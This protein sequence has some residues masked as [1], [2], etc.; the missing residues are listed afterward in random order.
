V[1]TELG[2][3][4]LLGLLLRDHLLGTKT[5]LSALALGNTATSTREDDIEVH[6][7]NTDGRIV[8]KTKIDVLLD[9]ET[10]VTLRGEASIRELELL[11]GKTLLENLLGLITLDGDEG[12]DLLITTNGEGTDGKA[13]GREDGLLVG[14]LL[15]HLCGTGQT[16]A[17]L[18]DT[19][20][21]HQF[22][23]AD[24]AHGVNL[25]L[26]FSALFVSIND[27]I[28]SCV[29]GEYACVQIKSIANWMNSDQKQMKSIFVDSIIVYL[30]E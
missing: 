7:I 24:V 17:R 18:T 12:G 11:D 30:I 20:V 25:L 1:T 10:E 14:Q 29:G 21:H 6:T 27:W 3:E 4:P 13:S 9:T 23:N 19:A 8:L 5:A 28:A 15:K 16:I 22:L 2:D 26:S